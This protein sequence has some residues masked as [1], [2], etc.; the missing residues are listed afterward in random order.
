MSQNARV[1]WAHK[2]GTVELWAAIS[3]FVVATL[4]LASAVT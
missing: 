3:M 2:L 4:I 1:E